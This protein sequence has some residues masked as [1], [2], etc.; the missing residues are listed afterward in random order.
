[1]ETVGKNNTEE[2]AWGQCVFLFFS[3]TSPYTPL[4]APYL[5]CD[6]VKPLNVSKS[7]VVH[8]YPG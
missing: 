4:L 7:Q 2:V 5:L 3:Y 1:M 6:L 8:L